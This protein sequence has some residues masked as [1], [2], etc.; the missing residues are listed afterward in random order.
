MPFDD[1]FNI[2]NGTLGSVYPNTSYIETPISSTPLG[3][4]SVAQVGITPYDQPAQDAGFWDA[5]RGK[6][7][8][9]PSLFSKIKGKLNGGGSGGGGAALMAGAGLLGTAIAGGYHNK[10]ADFADKASDV[11]G[12]IDPRLGAIGKIFAG[13]ANRL[14]GTKVNQ[15]KLNAANQGTNYLNSYQSNA[16]Y[17][18]DVKGPEAQAAVQDAYKGGLLV[19]GSA[20]KKN[21]ELRNQRV[22]A[23]L[24]ADRSVFNNVENIANTQMD[25]M[26]ANYAAYGGPLSVGLFPKGGNGSIFGR[27]NWGQMYVEG[28]DLNQDNSNLDA[29][30]LA[31]IANM[32]AEEEADGGP[33][34]YHTKLSSTDE[35]KYKKWMRDFTR[36]RKW[37]YYEQVDNPDYDY[38]GYWKNNPKEAQKMIKGDK[39]AHFTDRYKT[40]S[41]PTFSNES[42]YSNEKTPGGQWRKDRNG[43]DVY[44]P[45]EYTAQ[46]RN[47]TINEFQ[48]GYENGESP[49]GYYDSSTGKTIYPTKYKKNTRRNTRRMAFGGSLHTAGTDWSNGLIEIDNGGS[50]EE[51]PMEGVPFG[52]A[53]DGQPNLVEEGE[54]VFNDYV[55]SD[56]LKV[57]KAIR[58]MY[59]LRGQKDLTYAE[60]AKKIAKESEERPNDPISQRGLEA[61]LGDL[62]VAQE[63]SRQEMAMEE[64]AQERAE[65]SDILGAVFAANGGKITIKPSKKGT[66]TAE[67]TKHKMSVQEFADEVLNNPGAY[68]PGMVKK[69]N[70]A[71]NAASWK[72]A[73]GGSLYAADNNGFGHLF[74]GGG[75]KKNKSLF[76][77][78]LAQKWIDN[79]D[80]EDYA[81]LL[82]NIFGEKI[83]KELS[84]N[85]DRKALMSYALKG[86]RG[87]AYYGIHKNYNEYLA[88]N[89][90]EAYMAYRSL[91]PEIKTYLEGN[92]GAISDFT[93]LLDEDPDLDFSKVR[94]VNDFERV[95]RKEITDKELRKK[96]GKYVQT[97]EAYNRIINKYNTIV[98]ESLKDKD[99]YTG[100]DKASKEYVDMV[101]A[102]NP[103]RYP[104]KNE[105]TK[106]LFGTAAS[107]SGEEER[108]LR[109]DILGR[110]VPGMS[111]FS[112]SYTDVKSLNP[113]LDDE[114]A[115]VLGNR[116]IAKS[117]PY[118]DLRK[119]KMA[120]M[121]V[122]NLKDEPIKNLKWTEGRF[123]DGPY[124]LARLR[125]VPAIG[126]G[127]SAFSD[128][129]GWT[130]KPNYSYADS[131]LSTANNTRDVRFTPIG[132]YMRYT[133]LDRLYYANQLGA[134]AGATRRN[135]M[136]TSGNN[137]GIAMAGTLSA[138][139]NAQN[140]LGD[141]YRKAEE[142]NLG[143]RSA[144]A[145]FNRD[146]NMFNSENLLKAQAANLDNSK[147][148]TEAAIIAADMRAA[149]DERISKAKNANLT[150][151][152][153]SLGDIGR[154]AYT[155]EMIN[156]NPALYYMFPGGQ[157][158]PGTVGYKGTSGKAAKGGYL[159][160]KNKKKRR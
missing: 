87:P 54:V 131:I 115:I 153:N 80:D 40:P 36:S 107:F 126:H 47:R 9:K 130:N 113:I 114:R 15:E 145:D 64:A 27:V 50:H 21:Q 124:N 28:G 127:L 1:I 33:N 58:N 52:I 19:G 3:G 158:G 25:N 29:Q 43:R 63:Q 65:Q 35:R 137:R 116:L 39:K 140:Q 83:P 120:D 121:K 119:I 38:R 2:Y 150:N 60:A 51:N 110:Y 86:R 93:S 89:S 23:E 160:I 102:S 20:R 78:A 4:S 66:F 75:P 12:A 56:R 103:D 98:D 117:D 84:G 62:Q 11:I 142:Y 76:D 69:A 48:R 112:K 122:P 136:N 128:I 7:S 67:A 94:S 146:T 129:M 81:S 16:S 148:K 96:G 59:K 85:K 77:T 14:I 61:L 70:F 144:K 92:P 26:L 68:S 132:D 149:E 141:L 18:D 151:F 49:T 55:F 34:K 13:G 118:S 152:F 79:L 32:A 134:Q 95:L 138:D 123:E 57:P 24:Y 99:L 22:N 8:V 5:Y 37:N 42:I 53:E 100:L 156:S 133:P 139:Y 73:F 106:Y 157:F 6:D 71:R 97:P 44:V 30:T 10:V 125:F 17:F 45:S 147:I 46:F 155:L 90:K 31:A 109:S 135:I 159:T 74:K 91:P 108:A 41:H 143:Q 105:L 88:N 154:E 104:D 82:S 101:A 111:N 72:H